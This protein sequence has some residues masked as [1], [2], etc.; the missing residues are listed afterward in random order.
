MTIDHMSSDNFGSFASSRLNIPTIYNSYLEIDN[1]CVRVY[2]SLM[3]NFN[4]LAPILATSCTPHGGS[5]PL[6]L[7]SFIIMYLDDPW[8]LP[9]LSNSDEDTILTRVEMPLSVAKTAYHDIIDYIVDLGPDSSRT[10]EE[11]I[12]ALPVWKVVSS[13]SHD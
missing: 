10:E 7:V 1:V 13:C 5:S 2:P 8:N 9:S 6:S 4:I 3:G 12:F 11:D